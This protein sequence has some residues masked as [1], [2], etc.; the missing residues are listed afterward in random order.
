M[1]SV[2]NYLEKLNANTQQILTL[3]PTISAEQLT[4]KKDGEKWNI[5]EILEHF[6]MV[7]KGVCAQLINNQLERQ[8]QQELLGEKKLQTIIIGLRQKKVTSPANFEPSGK[9]ETVEQFVQ[10]L[11]KSRNW[12]TTRL[13]NCTIIIDGRTY[14]HPYL[15]V[16]A[17][18]DW[19]HFIINHC[20]RHLLQIQDRLTPSNN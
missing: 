12:L 13:T 7:E 20:E 14:P 6:L 3:L 18:T 8:E 2:P 1:L 9:I 19:L 17:I 5:I 4:M 16:M 11:L 15:G 10:Q